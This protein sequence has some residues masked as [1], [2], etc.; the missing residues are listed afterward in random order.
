MEYLN[1]EQI[2]V[3]IGSYTQ[4]S[5]VGIRLYSFH[6]GMGELTSLNHG[7]ELKN[8]SYIA[9]DNNRMRLFAVS[10]T[11]EYEGKAGGSVAAYDI[12]PQTGQLTLLN[13]R[14]TYGGAPCHLSLDQTGSCLYVANYLKG[15]VCVFPI[16]EDGKLGEASDIHQHEGKG[17]NASRQEGP[18][19]HSITPDFNNRFAI[20]ADLGIDQ[21]VIYDMDLAGHKL[22]AHNEVHLQAGAGPRHI[23]I[24]QKGSCLYVVNELNS[25]V[26]AMK[27]DAAAGFAAPFQTLSTLPRDFKGDNFGADIHL[28]PDERFLY[29]SNRGHDSIAAF[30]IDEQ[31]GTLTAIGHYSTLGNTPRNF[32]LTP[33]GD[34]LLAANQDTDDVRVWKVDKASGELTDTGHSIQVPKPVCIKMLAL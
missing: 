10:E 30:S 28:S 19:A 23:V 31:R 26:T 2:L 5:T 8:A 3:Y 14:P 16:E 1:K 24:R 34:Y 17:P 25:T 4:E 21:L 9:I 18:H 15:T 32:T 27:Y 12:D 11:E 20:A 6:P 13:Q 33:E 29:T 7:I 22:N